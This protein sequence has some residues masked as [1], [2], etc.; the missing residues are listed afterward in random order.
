MAPWNAVFT[1]RLST[2]PDLGPEADRL[3]ALLAA[4]PTLAARCHDTVGAELFQAMVDQSY[5]D[6]SDR[7]GARDSA[8]HAAVMTSRRRL[9]ALV[10]RSGAEGLS[11]PCYTCRTTPDAN[12]ASRVLELCVDAA[13]ALLVADAVPEEQ[14][15]LLTRPVARLV[16]AQRLG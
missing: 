13:C 11:R 10:Q 3:K 8:F 2:E 7:A 15:A 14:L 16:P 1:T 5:V 9:W 4:L 6:E 12:E